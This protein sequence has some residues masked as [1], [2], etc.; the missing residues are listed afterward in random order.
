MRYQKFK[1]VKKVFIMA[2]PSR[3]LF[4]L[5]S[6]FIFNT[7][8]SFSSPL[9]EGY[10]FACNSHFQRHGRVREDLSDSEAGFHVIKTKEEYQFRLKDGNRVRS[11]EGHPEVTHYE[12]E[13]QIPVHQCGETKV[14][15][16]HP[17]GLALI[18]C[19]KPGEPGGFLDVE[20][21]YLTS[22]KNIEERQILEKTNKK[23]NLKIRN[24]HRLGATIGASNNDA[25][26]FGVVVDFQKDN[27][28]TWSFGQTRFQRNVNCYSTISR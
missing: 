5:G 17:R 25:S 12:I 9:P 15:G 20:V 11:F 26:A 4:L 19:E 14:P 10:W 2:S 18:T 21:T 23:L 24:I 27:G 1:K 28:E 22:V 7:P 13:F 3:V 16:P 8:H 6:F